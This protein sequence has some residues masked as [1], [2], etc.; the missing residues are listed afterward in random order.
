[1][2]LEKHTQG[3]TLTILYIH[4][5]MDFIRFMKTSITA[6]YLAKLT[7]SWDDEALSRSKSFAANTE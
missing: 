4:T 5:A 2:C 3:L 1:M 6:V 7:S